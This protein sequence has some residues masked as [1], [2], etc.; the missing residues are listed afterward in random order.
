MQIPNNRQ[1]QGDKIVVSLYLN[2]WRSEAGGEWAKA[3]SPFWAQKCVENQHFKLK[4][5]E[6]K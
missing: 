5:H 6:Q 1:F 3:P 4:K 2:Q